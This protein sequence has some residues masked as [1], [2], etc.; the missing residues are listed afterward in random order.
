[1][2][3]IFSVFDVEATDVDICFHEELFL[4]LALVISLQMNGCFFMYIWKKSLKIS[5]E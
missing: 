5:K 3:N 4:L 2:Y 1:M